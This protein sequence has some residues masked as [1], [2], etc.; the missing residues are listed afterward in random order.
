[1]TT[2]YVSSKEGDVK[3]TNLPIVTQYYRGRYFRTLR[4]VA[5]TPSGFRMITGHTFY[6][7]SSALRWFWTIDGTEGSWHSHKYD[8]SHMTETAPF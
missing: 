1:M 8:D 7:Q 4:T 6:A 3:V 5:T 2:Q